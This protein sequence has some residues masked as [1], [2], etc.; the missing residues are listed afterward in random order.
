M[1]NKRRMAVAKAMAMLTLSVLLAM[2]SCWAESSVFIRIDRDD[3]NAWSEP[4]ANVRFLEDE[5][6]LYRSR[7]CAKMRS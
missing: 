1:I 2:V 3:P 5:G 4:L 7:M 6:I